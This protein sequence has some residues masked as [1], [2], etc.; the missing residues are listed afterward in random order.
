MLFRYDASKELI[1]SILAKVK[2]V[3]SLPQCLESCPA[4]SEARVFL[5]PLVECCPP[6][7]SHE[8]RLEEKSPQITAQFNLLPSNSSIHHSDWI[9]PGHVTE[10]FE[11]QL[12]METEATVSI[13]NVMSRSARSTSNRSRD[14]LQ[15]LHREWASAALKTLH[16]VKEQERKK[17]RTKRSQHLGVYP[18]L[19]LLPDGDYVDIIINHISQLPKSGEPT[20]NTVFSIGNKVFSRYALRQYLTEE[21]SARLQNLY[22]RYL[23]LFTDKDSRSV[24]R[25]H[26]E[27]LERE[28]GCMRREELI[29]PWQNFWRIMVGKKLLEI[30]VS[31]FAVEIGGKDQVPSAYFK[32][33]PAVYNS[34]RPWGNRICGMTV[35]HP[36]YYQLVQAAKSD[37]KFEADLLPMVIPPLPWISESQGA[38][39]CRPS[40]FVRK[41]ITFPGPS[42]GLSAVF[43]A[44]N[45]QGSVAWRINQRIL[46]V[47]LEIFRLEGNPDLKIAPAPPAI[48]LE[49]RYIRGCSPE[50]RKERVAAY[51][52]AKK[53][54]NEMNSLHADALYKFSIADFFRDKLIWLPHNLDFRGR[55]YPIPPHFNY[56]GEIFMI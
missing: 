35:P 42:E 38:F 11:Q 30:M 50:K 17:W 43:D 4:H 33:I 23:S 13:P 25:K 46:D 44:L 36:V 8:H 2:Q 12:S 29:R 32:D 15:G 37:F 6:S 56:M 47:Q 51:H 19:C 9:S 7:I 28:L 40:E 18:F 27:S 1:D 41:T 21:S 54:S 26:W 31:T 39:L 45:I 16:L 49:L 53:Q 48:P 20:L 5:E 10:L 22:F 24:P 55:S 14:A 52:R 3:H 34:Y